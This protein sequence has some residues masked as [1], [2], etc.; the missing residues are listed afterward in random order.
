MADDHATRWI[1]E[2]SNA[3]SFCTAVGANVNFRNRIHN[4]IAFNV[5]ITMEPD[6]P[7]HI[8]EIHEVNQLEPNTIKSAR[9]VKPIA[10]RSPTQGTAHLIILYTDINAAN[11]ALA[12][13]LQICHRKVSIEKIRKEPVRCLKCQQWNHYA[14]ECTAALDT[15]GNCAE[16]HRTSQCPDH[17][18]RR[19]AS[20]NCTDHASW[21]R[22][23]PIFL[24]KRDEC[25]RRN[26]ENSLPFI[27]SDEPWTWTPRND[28]LGRYGEVYSEA[29]ANSRQPQSNGN[30]APDSAQRD[31]NALSAQ[32]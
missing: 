32:T 25:N 16:K 7:T 19:C 17:T 11:R 20:C 31:W 14:K 3:R 10:R 22:E 29:N 30:R 26:L 24:R 6:N 23:C 9:W 8:K 2:E 27:P 21:S 15:C 4:L 12:N 1:K 5:P 13:G 28:F 18:K